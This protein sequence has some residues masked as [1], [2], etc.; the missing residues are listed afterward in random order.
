MTDNNPFSRHFMG[1]A[2]I[3]DLIRDHDKDRAQMSADLL[4]RLGQKG[5]DEYFEDIRSRLNIAAL[6]AQGAFPVNNMFSVA[7]SVFNA[8]LISDISTSLAAWAGVSKQAENGGL[9]KLVVACEA[10]IEDCFSDTGYH[11]GYGITKIPALSVDIKKPPEPNYQD[12]DVVQVRLSY[13]ANVGLVHELS[14]SLAEWGSKVPDGD[15]R[16]LAFGKHIRGALDEVFNP[17]KHLSVASDLSDDAPE[18]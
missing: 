4:E 16:Y 5:V 17:A 15:G 13:H 6:N 10:A 1:K 8:D 14:R 11:Q 2:E 3:A 18:A 7:Q 9:E 12:A